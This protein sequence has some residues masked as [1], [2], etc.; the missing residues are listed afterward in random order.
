MKIILLLVSIFGSALGFAILINLLILLDTLISYLKTKSELL[1]RQI[2]RYDFG[3]SK[4]Y[5]DKK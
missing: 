3:Y 2:E 1:N 4:N 5:N